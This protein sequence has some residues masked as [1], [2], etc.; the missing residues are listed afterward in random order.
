MTAPRSRKPAAK[1]TAPAKRSGQRSGQPRGRPAG[2]PCALLRDEGDGRTVHDVLVHY[3]R[4]GADVAVAAGKAHVTRSAVYDW[5]HEGARI[6]QAVDT[7]K[8]TPADLDAKDGAVLR[9]ASLALEAVA[10]AEADALENVVRLGAGGAT[11]KR[12]TRTYEGDGEAAKIVGRVEVEEE[13]PPLLGANVFLLERRFSE[14][15]ARPEQIAVVMGQNDPEAVPESPLPA[16]LAALESMEQRRREA[17]RELAGGA[18]S[19]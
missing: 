15:W 3:L 13:L 8:V 5:L 16:L 12:V 1:A 7:G 18:A 6:A 9:F 2:L 4:M 14:R 11:R 10:T 19:G 17:E